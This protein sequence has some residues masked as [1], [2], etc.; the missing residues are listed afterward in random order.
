MNK[1]IRLAMVGILLVTLLLMV[2]PVAAQTSDLSVKFVVLSVS[3][4]DVV[5]RATLTNTSTLPQRSITI[6]TLLEGLS[7]PLTELNY[8]KVERVQKEQYQEPIYSAGNE[9]T[10]GTLIGYETKTREVKASYRN[11]SFAGSVPDTKST[12]TLP[13]YNA[14]RDGWGGGVSVL[15]FT[16]NT[17]LQ[18]RYDSQGKFTGWGSKGVLALDIDGEEFKDLVNSSWWNAAW[19]YRNLLA[20]NASTISENLTDFPVT[21]FFD[22]SNLDF[23]LVAAG[24]IDIRIIDKDGVTEI[25]YEREL[26][27][28]VGEEAVIHFKVPQVDASSNY[29]D[30]AYIYFG[31]ATA[32]DGEDRTNVWNSGYVAVWHM[33]DLTTSSIRDSTVNGNTGTKQADN[34]P[35]E[36]AGLV[37]KAQQFVAADT[38]LITGNHTASLQSTANLTLETLVYADN[39]SGFQTIAKKT[40]ASTGYQFYKHPT[41]ENVTGLAN[42]SDEFSFGTILVS[43]WYHY[44][45]TFD[46]N[47]SPKHRGYKDGSQVV[48]SSIEMTASTTA[49]LRI[50]AFVALNNDWIGL[51]DEIRVSNVIRSAQW[52]KATNMSLRNTLLYYDDT[53]PPPTLATLPATGITMDKDGVTG[54]NFSGNLTSLGGAPTVYY[55]WEYGLTDSYGSSS[56]NTSTGTTGVK[57]L[58]IPTTLTPGATYHFRFVGQNVEGTTYGSDD[59]VTLTMPSITTSPITN[60]VQSYP[61][62]SA[63][64]NGNV[65]S[66]GVASS[67][68]VFWQYGVTTGFG[69]VTSSQSVN[70]TGA[71]STTIIDFPWETT[72]HTRLVAQ[73]DDQ[74]VY[75]ADVSVV[76][77]G[78]LTTFFGLRSL[79][80]LFPVLLLV[81]MIVGAAIFVGH[82]MTSFRAKDTIQGLTMFVMS[83]LF[84]I[85]SLILLVIV[86]NALSDIIGV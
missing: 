79:L 49:T 86:M 39:I 1:I 60:V 71:V 59:D 80:V 82:G 28:D 35:V 13:G 70:S 52:L 81:G 44:A 30:Y 14:D 16:I 68:Y 7:I 17:G 21:A 76:V 33:N 15:D 72:L 75:G 51:I 50:G 18:E 45:W 64:L 46:N 43:T 56:S 29:T 20:F 54:G 9:I 42:N 73:V 23:S 19:L 74:Y 36:A 84:I 12:T 69:S 8:V 22:A 47:A 31:N 85:I 58:A 83:V 61:S 55:W 37:G 11:W 3:P 38:D 66:L 41:T 63:T 53:A 2:A 5:I 6:N 4:V 25:P 27:D 77:G 34:L 48:T 32:P 24:G 78:R 10:P 57:T 40:G 62:T 65:S 67:A 26:W